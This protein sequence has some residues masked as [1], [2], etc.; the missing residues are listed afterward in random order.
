VQLVEEAV[1]DEAAEAEDRARLVE[2]FGE[3]E[4]DSW[5]T[6]DP[7]RDAVEEVMDQVEGASSWSLR[8]P[9]TYD[10]QRYLVSM[11]PWSPRLARRIRRAVEARGAEVEVREA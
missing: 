6:S 10:G 3:E 8:P 7:V 1:G 4:A 9:S 11:R 5:F 2:L